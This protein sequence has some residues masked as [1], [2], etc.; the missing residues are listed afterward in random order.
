MRGCD[1]SAWGGQVQEMYK[2]IAY[3]NGDGLREVVYGFEEFVDGGEKC[4]QRD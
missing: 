2:F 4:S 3:V 1:L